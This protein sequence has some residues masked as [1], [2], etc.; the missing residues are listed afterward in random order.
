MSCHAIRGA[1]LAG[2]NPLISLA[3][4]IIAKLMK[5]LRFFIGTFSKIIVMYS[6]L[7][8]IQHAFT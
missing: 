5:K 8:K 6:Y 4:N 3:K 7:A 1:S 2:L